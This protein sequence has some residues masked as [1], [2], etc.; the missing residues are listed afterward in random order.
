M[1]HRAVRVSL[2]GVLAVCGWAYEVEAQTVT[3]NPYPGITYI[4]RTETM[5]YFR[6]PGCP[7][8]PPT[9]Y[10]RMNIVLVDLTAPEIHFKL[11]PQG[12]NLPPALPGSTGFGIEP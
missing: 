12:T 9:R 7:A 6:C 5:P 1:S 2:V 10:A 8:P 11:T 4:K 3:T